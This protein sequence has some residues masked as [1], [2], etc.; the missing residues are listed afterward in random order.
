MADHPSPSPSDVP[1][2]IAGMASLSGNPNLLVS[3]VP[4]IPPELKEKLGQYLNARSAGLSDVAPEGDAVLITTRFGNT[5]QLHLVERPMG[6]RRQLTFFEE[7]IAGGTFARSPAGRGSNY[8]DQQPIYF[9]QDVGGGEFYQI[10]RLDRKTGRPTL[11]TDGRSRHGGVALSPDGKLAAFSSTARNGRD[12]DVYVVDLASP[13]T[14]AP[15]N[16]ATAAR[17]ITEQAGTWFPVDFSPDG[18]RL[19][20]GQYRSIDDSDLWLANVSSG[21]RVRL[22]PP[23]GRGSVGSAAFSADGRAVYYTT[24]RYT[25]YNELYR[26][27]LTPDGHAPLQEAGTAEPT[28]LTRSIRWNVEELAVAPDGSAVAM[29]VNEDGLS[30]IYL[31]N[32]ATGDLKGIDLPEPGVI[33]TLTFPRDRSNV[34]FL[35]ADTSRSPSDVFSYALEEGRFTRWTR[36]EVGGLDTSRFVIPELVRYPSAGGVTV[37]AILYLPGENAPAEAKRDGKWPVLVVFH[38]G[39]EGQSR[40]NYSSFVQF[41][42][43]ELGIAVLLPNVRGSD[44]YGKEFLAMDNGIKREE[45]LKDI[46]ATL[47]WIASRPDLD[48]DRVG[49]YGGSYGGYMVLAAGVFYPERIRAIVDV[50]GISSIPSFLENTQSYRRDLRRAEYGDERDPEV[51]KVQERISPLNH[52]EKIKAALFVQQG[53]NDPR[54]PQSEAEQ[55][56]RAVRERHGG[57]ESA[58]WYLL[59]LDEGHGFAKKGNR[60]QALQAT[61]LFLRKKLLE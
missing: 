23:T 17:R 45:S 40:P 55:I 4:E 59:A 57:R 13:E 20:V 1:T 48:T 41:L 50:V 61:V 25:D 34:L 21:E 52:V 56:V 58:A 60:D 54:V 35:S 15:G 26:I 44:G 24:D 27:D 5:S 8:A 28:A 10:Y 19:L 31:L 2:S 30:R 36:S 49:A 43:N 33:G 51:R 14:S 47:D 46:G 9:L 18:T 32:P 12:T 39:P 38:G 11:L 16:W 22:T 37:P 7:P 53:K 42:A 29:A 6:A 3:G